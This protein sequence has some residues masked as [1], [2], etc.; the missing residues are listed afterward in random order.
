MSEPRVCLHCAGCEAQSKCG[1]APSR[2]LWPV[3][4]SLPLSDMMMHEVMWCP[5]HVALRVSHLL[6]V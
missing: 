2:A 6:C 3:R 5:I 4:S 1:H